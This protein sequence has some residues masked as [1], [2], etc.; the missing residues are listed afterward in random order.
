M[1]GSGER[2]EI[3]PY[4]AVRAAATASAIAAI[5]T[6]ERAHCR[7]LTA[8]AAIAGRVAENIDR[9]AAGAAGFT[10]TAAAR[11]RQEAAGIAAGAAGAGIGVCASR[12]AAAAGATAARRDGGTDRAGRED[13]QRC[14]GNE[15]RAAQRVQ[16]FAVGAMHVVRMRHQA[17]PHHAP[18]TTDVAHLDEYV[19]TLWP[20]KAIGQANDPNNEQ[21][22][23][24]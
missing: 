17:G 1:R 12:A 15:K 11:A 10:R 20:T 22:Q 5:A 23:S 16:A 8:G 21:D 9:R 19:L 2:G 24:R 13:R 14:D 3:G 6:D 7:R 4:I 18:T